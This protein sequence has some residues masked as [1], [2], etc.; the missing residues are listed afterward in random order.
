L[1]DATV[2]LLDTTSGLAG[3]VAV[4]IVV[5]TSRSL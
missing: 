5:A 1:F 2:S 4:F 3:F